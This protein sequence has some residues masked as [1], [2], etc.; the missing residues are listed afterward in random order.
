AQFQLTRPWPKS[1]NYSL[2]DGT[3]S[4]RALST[5]HIWGDGYWIW[6]IVLRGHRLSLGVTY[7]QHR[8]PPGR[9]YRERFWNVVQ[10]YPVL[11]EALEGAEM[12]EFQ[13][14]KNVQYQTK[15]NISERRFALC[16][17]A[18]TLIDAYYSQGM[19][20]SFTCAWHVGNLIEEDLRRSHLD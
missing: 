14:Y 10:R 8:T 4:D 15:T 20:N 3:V 16:G 5:T 17:D 6:V 13:S 18:A 19:A 2:P 12:L 1:W 9:D 7:A 11:L